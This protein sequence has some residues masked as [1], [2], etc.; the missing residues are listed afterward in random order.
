MAI[1]FFL[2]SKL[3]YIKMLKSYPRFNLTLN[4]NFTMGE[5]ELESK[6]ISKFHPL[7]YKFRTFYVLPPTS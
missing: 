7:N 6:K 5:D 4:L 1:C 2:E 3:F